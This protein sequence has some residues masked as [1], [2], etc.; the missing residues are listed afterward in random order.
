MD[1][2]NLTIVVSIHI[3]KP[4]S[5]VQALLMTHGISRDMELWDMEG[6]L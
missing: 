5:R 6:A 4:Q 3:Y 2:L 1:P